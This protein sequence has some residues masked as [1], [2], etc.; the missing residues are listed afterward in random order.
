MT[1]PVVDLADFVNG[2]P[3]TEGCFCSKARPGL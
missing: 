1:I 2:R 3:G